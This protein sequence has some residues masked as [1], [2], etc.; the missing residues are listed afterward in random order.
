MVLRM[1]QDLLYLLNILPD[2]TYLSVIVLFL[3]FVKMVLLAMERLA[4]YTSQPAAQKTH[5]PP[6]PLPTPTFARPASQE[7]PVIPDHYAA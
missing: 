4:N 1:G 5:I 3:L 2:F 6:S 7:K